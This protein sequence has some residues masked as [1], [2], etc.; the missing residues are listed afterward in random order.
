MQMFRE[1]GLGI[2]MRVWGKKEGRRE[3]REEAK[4]R[5]EAEDRRFPRP[6][7]QDCTEAALWDLAARLLH[8]AWLWLW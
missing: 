1:P 7:Q 8:L 4:Q 6:R 5:G 2:Q 3:E